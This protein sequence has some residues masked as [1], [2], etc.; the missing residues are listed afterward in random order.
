MAII[1]EI[2]W[3]SAG[4][5][6]WHRA[7]GSASSLLEATA[8]SR[9][10]PITP[11]RGRVWLCRQSPGDPQRGINAR[12]SS[13]RST[14]PCPSSTMPV[15]RRLAYLVPLQTEQSIEQV[16]TSV[17]KLCAENTCC[18]WFVRCDIHGSPGRGPHKQERAGAHA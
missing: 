9:S 15:R 11:Y 8:D 4:P 5:L 1:Q 10:V 2:S 13:A 7:E 12:Y 16:A 18:P 6:S 17:P 14:P 3:Q